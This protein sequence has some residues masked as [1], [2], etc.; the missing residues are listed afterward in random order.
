[1]PIKAKKIFLSLFSGLTFLFLGL[2]TYAQAAGLASH[3]AVYDLSLIESRNGGGV[4]AA[5]GRIVLD[6][7][8]TCEGHIVNQ[9]ML[10][11]LQ[12]LGGGVVVSDYYLSTYET[13]DGA[14]LRFTVS[15]SINGEVIEK[16]DG[17][18]T[19][20]TQSG[21]VTFSDDDIKPID[22]PKGVLFPTQHTLKILDAA[23][24]G[25]NLLSAKVYD[26]N[27]EDG[28]QDSLTIIGKTK[29]ETSELLI[30][31]GGDDWKSWYIQ[32]SFFDLGVQASEPD[33]KVSY[34]MFENG[35]GD[36]ITLEYKDFSMLGRLVQ[37]EFKEQEKC[38]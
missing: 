10:V 5:R 19:K 11:E 15:N 16:A 6:F 21:E 8:N 29:S 30:E 9:R 3:R 32:M 13:L 33:Y 22:L 18:A 4:E 17:V 27:G 26:G 1:M 2:Q 34:Q 38:N 12:N 14:S 37:I 31:Q 24:Q 20:N 36:N 7:D 28:L 35:V 23:R 25:N